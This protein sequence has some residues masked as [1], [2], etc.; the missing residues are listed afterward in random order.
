MVGSLRAR[1]PRGVAVA[2]G[3]AAGVLSLAGLAAAGIGVAPEEP[4]LVAAA[5]AY[6]AISV[7]SITTTGAYLLLEQSLV[8]PAVTGVGFA[9]TAVA[10]LFAASGPAAERFLTKWPW[11][12]AAVLGGGIAE[13]VLR[14]ALES[15]TGRFGPRPLA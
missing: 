8:A 14:R 3:A 13:Y 1:S 11:A 15:V 12:A 6:V 5:L 9:A 2:T 10:G 7:A 4:G